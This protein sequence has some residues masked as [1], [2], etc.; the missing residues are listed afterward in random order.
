[1][2]RQGNQPRKGASLRRSYAAHRK[3]K[4]PAATSSSTLYLSN[5]L[6][7]RSHGL[8]FFPLVLVQT[9]TFMRDRTREPD[10][11]FVSH[12][13]DCN[14]EMERDEQPATNAK[15]PLPNDDGRT[16]TDANHNGP[17]ESTCLADETSEDEENYEVKPPF[18][19]FCDHFGRVRSLSMAVLT[20]R[21]E[22]S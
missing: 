6:D 11:S 7:I 5:T 14:Y 9:T 10:S 21:T 13:R 1:M 4:V 18:F 12:H 3:V 17:V 16:E 20:P 15:S 8:I 22:Q 2:P 19:S